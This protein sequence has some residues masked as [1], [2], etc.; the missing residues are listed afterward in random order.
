MSI[1]TDVAGAR[2][3][4]AADVAV[5][6]AAPL[7]L[8][9]IYIGVIFLIAVWAKLRA[10]PSFTPNLVGFLQHLALPNAHAFYRP[11]LTDVVIPHAGFFATVVTAAELLV[12][13]ALVTG[14]ATRLAAAGAMVLVLNYMF[15]K[16]AWFWM[17]SSNDS[18][19]FFIA[20]AVG[21]ARAGR[22]C[23]VDRVLAR[24]WPTVPLW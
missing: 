4:R 22:V 20:L 17:P 3:A 18:A 11:F 5:P 8:L 23:G 1:A 19:F 14:T 24:R 12:G 16:G 10:E 21:W 2:D 9:R 13:L 15:A 6:P 7:V